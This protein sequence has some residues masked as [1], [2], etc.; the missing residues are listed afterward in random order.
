MELLICG[1]VSWSEC[2]VAA[3]F[4][5]TTRLPFAVHQMATGLTW[6]RDIAPRDL[7]MASYKISGH[8]QSFLAISRCT[9]STTRLG[10]GGL[11]PATAEYERGAI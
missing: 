2:V 8:S 7:L 6:G 1:A 11:T 3:V 9:R 4:P 5:V 10:L